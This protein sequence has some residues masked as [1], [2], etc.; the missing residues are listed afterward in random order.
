MMSKITRLQNGLTVATAEMP[1]MAS[2]SLGLWVGVGGRHEAK[3]LNGVTH[4]IEHMLFKGTR[5][6]SA[7]EISQAVEGI[8][9]Y[10][11]AFTTEEHTCFYARARHHQFEELLEVL[12]DMFLNSTFAPG[13]IAKER[14]VIKEELA[15]ELDQPHHHVQELL[16]ETLWP[17]HPLGRPLTGTE[18]SLAALGRSQLVGYQRAHHVGAAALVVAAGHV[19]HA[20][21]VQAVERFARRFAGGAPPQFLPYT[22]AQTAPRV[23][24]FT[25]ETAQTQMALGL[26]ACSRHDSRRYALRVLNALLGENMSSRLFQVVREDRG[27]AYSIHSSLGFFDDVGSLTI[28][29]GLDTDHLAQVLRLIG[30]EL[31]RCRERTPTVAEMRRARDY[32][33]G[34]ID[35]GLEGTEH[36]MM[37]VGEQWLAYGRMVS[38]REVKKRLCE[39]T[40]AE[41]RAAARDFFQPERASLAVVSPMKGQGR[42]E[43]MMK[44]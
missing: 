42:L 20:R 33:V 12:M 19:R 10:L 40:P 22:A 35:L 13:E 31:R 44:F 17:D 8:G 39:V 27:L 1:H 5:R 3:E 30:R 41:V 21:V 23:R 29:A 32:L 2:V 36:Q 9:G 14:E 15:M 7:R 6:R 18:A 16:N 26:V 25:R 28:S 11:N 37:W 4:F 34:Q 43:G 24:L 38:A